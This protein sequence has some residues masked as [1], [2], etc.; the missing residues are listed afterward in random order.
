MGREVLTLIRWRWEILKRS[1][2]WPEAILYVGLPLGGMVAFFAGWAIGRHLETLATVFLWVGLAVLYTVVQAVILGGS[3][4]HVLTTM[5]LDSDLELVMAAPVHPS[6]VFLTR[7]LE[8]LAFPGLALTLISLFGVWGVGVGAN[9]GFLFYPTALLAALFLPMLPASIA[10]VLT[11]VMVRYLPAWRLREMLAVAGSVLWLGY[12][13]LQSVLWKSLGKSL[14]PMLTAWLMGNEALGFFATSPGPVPAN[15]AAWATI[16]AGLGR[17]DRAA[18]PFLGFVALSLAAFTAVVLAAERLYLSGWASVGVVQRRR[19]RVQSVFAREIKW[20]PR[21]V[22]AVVR[23]DWLL[24]RRDPRRMLNL[25]WP[26]AYVFAATRGNYPAGAASVVS[27]TFS[28]DVMWII[29]LAM[30]SFVLLVFVSSFSGGLL[31]EEGKAVWLLRSAP[32]SEW[33]WVMAKFW[34]GFLP[35]LLG[36]VLFLAVFALVEGLGPGGILRGLGVAVVEGMGLVAL[37][38]TLPSTT[39]ATEGEARA[40]GEGLVRFLLS[41]AYLLVADLILV[42][43]MTRY[44]TTWFEQWVLAFVQAMGVVGGTALVIWLALT[45]TADRLRAREE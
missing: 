2:P 32:L 23:K 18:V 5:Y 8:V 22:W 39:W 9:M 1:S 36:S 11:M 6:A 4:A 3:M 19:R 24:V 40:S 38:L 13:T 16:A 12:Y 34:G 31:A 20:G 37:S 35:T 15:W 25:L 17:P 7:L 45:W 26:V 44:G 10:A 28:V 14:W 33:E 30:T 21:R 43:P 42:L 29:Q 41:V 27:A